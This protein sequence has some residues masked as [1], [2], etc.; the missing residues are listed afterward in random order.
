MRI[1]KRVRV[2]VGV[3]FATVA[4]SLAVAQEDPSALRK[5]SFDVEE[6]TIADIHHAYRSGELSALKLVDIYLERI[7]KH[8]APK[9]LKAFVA[10]NPKARARAAALDEELARTGKLRPLHGIPV[11]VK[12]NYD[13]H[14]LQTS[15]GSI[16]LAGSLPPDD[17]FMVERIR[18]AGAIVIGKSNMDEWAFSHG[19][20]LSRAR[21]ARTRRRRTFAG[22]TACVDRSKSGAD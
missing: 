11:V 2:L 20:G 7:A 13:T 4:L 3:Y 19:A 9:D 14:D 5:A 1:I 17:C 21:G 8:D 15:G 10:L 12:D 6:A 16:A 18:A 22:P